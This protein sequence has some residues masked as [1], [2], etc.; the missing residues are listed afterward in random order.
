MA[1]MI[2]QYSPI[3][4]FSVLCSGLH[5]NLDECFVFLLL[6]KKH[7]VTMSKKQLAQVSP[8]HSS[9]KIN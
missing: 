8:Y 9:L 7:L 1:S 2:A 5:Y 4:K 3:S 6:S